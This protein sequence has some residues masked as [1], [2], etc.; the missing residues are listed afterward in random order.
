MSNPVPAGD[1]T[2]RS[3]V[4]SVMQAERLR[5]WLGEVLAAAHHLKMMLAY[6]MYAKNGCD[7]PQYSLSDA[8]VT[9]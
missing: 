3:G 5:D 9:S 8:I 2:F 4:V 1:G 7:L 6:E